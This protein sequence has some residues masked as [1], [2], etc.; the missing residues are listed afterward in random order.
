MENQKCSLPRPLTVIHY[1][2]IRFRSKMLHIKCYNSIVK[3]L[4]DILAKL[5]I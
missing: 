4:F 2:Y 1:E 5:Y 3:I